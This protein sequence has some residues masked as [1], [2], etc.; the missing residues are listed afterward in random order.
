MEKPIGGLKGH[1]K[2]R[3]REVAAKRERQRQ[4]WGRGGRMQGS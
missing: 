4:R 2:E 3:V 1:R